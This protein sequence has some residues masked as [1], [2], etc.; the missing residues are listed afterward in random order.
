MY[1]LSADQLKSLE[2]FIGKIPD[3]LI[4]S[5]CEKWLEEIKPTE[6]ITSELMEQFVG[7]STHLPVNLQNF[8]Q[9]FAMAVKNTPHLQ[10]EQQDSKKREQIDLNLLASESIKEVK[11]IEPTKK[12]EEPLHKRDIKPVKKTPLAKKNK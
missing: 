5:R 6:K 12:K 3:S 9:S 10:E 7:F 1:N 11:T 8:P 2:T 4:K